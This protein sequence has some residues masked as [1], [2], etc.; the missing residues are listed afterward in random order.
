MTTRKILLEALDKATAAL[1]TAARDRALDQ[2]R[3]ERRDEELATLRRFR[4]T[5]TEQLDTKDAVG[6]IAC[7]KQRA[8]EFARFEHCLE[9]ERRKSYKICKGQEVDVEAEPLWLTFGRA[10]AQRDEAQSDR[11]ELVK[12]LKTLQAEVDCAA[13]TKLSRDASFARIETLLYDADI[14]YMWKGDK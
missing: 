5:V 12:L 3:I 2:K 6:E 1:D 4:H 9:E 10:V 11:E 7:L 8:D 13:C 14:N